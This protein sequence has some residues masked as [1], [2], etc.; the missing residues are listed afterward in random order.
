VA[1]AHALSAYCDVVAMTVSAGYELHAAIFD[2]V[3]RGDGW[4]FAELREALDRGF[5]TGIQSM[6]MWL[7]EIGGHRTVG[8]RSIVRAERI[9]SMRCSND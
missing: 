3:G 4:A 1:F 8:L 7:S 6:R 5:L 2:A 9:G